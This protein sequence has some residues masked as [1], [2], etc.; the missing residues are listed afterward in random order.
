MEIMKI[1]KI[2]LIS[3][4]L[5]TGDFRQNKDKNSNQIELKKKRDKKHLLNIPL[6]KCALENVRFYFQ[7]SL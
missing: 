7:P 4:V 3:I 6:P 2:K 1:M 5:L